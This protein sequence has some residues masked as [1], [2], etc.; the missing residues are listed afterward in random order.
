[1]PQT[2][3]SKAD[4]RELSDLFARLAAALDETVASLIG[5][6]L[7]VRPLEVA[8]TARD[9]LLAALPCA[10]AAVRGAL[11]ADHAGHC[12]VTLLPI[13]DACAMAGLL[14]M[15][16]D[17][18]IAESRERGALEG[19]DLE[20]FGELGNV[21]CSGFG[22]VLREAQSEAD[23]R[24]LDHGTVQPGADPAGLL[25]DG[26]LVA[27]R[28]ALEIGGFP[29]SHALLVLD[30]T[31]GEAWNRGPLAATGARGGRPAG[32]GG[33][34]EALRLDELGLRIGED[35]LADVPQAPLRGVLN[36]YLASSESLRLLRRSCRRVGLEL[37][38]HNRAEIPNPAAHRGEIVLMD[39]PNG[40]ERRFDWGRRIKN[41]AG[42]T[43]VVLLI[44]RPSRT[45][46]MQALL[47]RADVIVGM[48][49]E[50]P[51]LSSKLSSLFDS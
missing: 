44:H 18:L 11:E 46:V 30:R 6:P 10:H 32:E 13:P 45:R 26:Q 8:L 9:E 34:A 7:G 37:R 39:V 20:A 16:P 22:N 51:Q 19:Q 4:C 48:P 25:P 36:A 1:M 41:Y 21:L 29:A 27:C 50:E 28:L 5:R 47:S 42:D 2:I 43:K 38:V 3:L 35:D 33:P 40:E 15:T 23:I 12:L 17:H 49:I 24:L 14:M 31:T